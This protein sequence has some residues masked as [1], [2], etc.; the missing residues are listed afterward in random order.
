MYSHS[1][2]VNIKKSSVA[3]AVDGHSY[4][5]AVPISDRGVVEEEDVTEASSVIRGTVG[6]PYCPPGAPQVEA[7]VSDLVVDTLTHNVAVIARILADDSKYGEV[8][9][10]WRVGAGREGDDGVAI[11]SHGRLLQEDDL[12]RNHGI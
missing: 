8:G 3:E 1:F 12:A 2:P 9:H 5:V 11:E 7:K 10:E 4:G 6:Q